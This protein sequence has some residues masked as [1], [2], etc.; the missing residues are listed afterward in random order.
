MR[1]YLISSRRHPKVGGPPAWGLGEGANT[2]Y[3]KKITDNKQDNKKGLEFLW[4]LWKDL[5]K[6]KWR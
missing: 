2:S 3:R 1:L 5:G 4:I 6:G